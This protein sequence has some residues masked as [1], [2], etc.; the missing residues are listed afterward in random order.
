MAGALTSVLAV[1]VAGLP[2][3]AAPDERP[4]AATS[5]APRTALTDDA[6]LQRSDESGKR[7]EVLGRRTER[8]QTFANPDGT[9]TV[10]QYAQP[11]RTRKGGTWTDIDTTLVKQRNGTLAPRAT[12][13]AVTLSGGGDGPFATLVRDGRT[14]SLSWPG[15]LPA[16]E[17]EGA[18]A[19]YRAVLPDVDL[20]VR[21]EP[22]GFA[23]L[24]VVKSAEAAANPKLTAIDMPVETRG[25]DLSEAAGGGLV[26]KDPGT[27]GTVF[28][29]PQPVMWDSSGES[30]PAGRQKRAAAAPQAAPGDGARVADVSLGLRRDV[31]TLK[32]DMSLLRGENTRYPVIIDPV[33]RTKSRTAWTWVSSAKPGLEG[34]KF[35][36]SE[37]GVES[38]K[39][40]GRC[41]ANF[42]VRCTGSDDVQRQYY[43]L[44]TGSFE[45]KRILKAE[46][47]ITLVHTYNSEARSVQLH[48]VNSSGGSAINSRTNWSN[49]PS[50]K[51][52]ITSE[53]P[54]N[55]TGS[56]SATNQNVR[57]NVKGTV[58]KA[59][60][61]GWDTTTFGLQAAT[62][63]SYASWKRFCNNAALEVTYNRPPYQPRM[64]DLSM[65][66]GGKCAYGEATK[67]Y[68]K[69]VPTLS[70]EIWDPDHGDAHG[71]TETLRAQFEI[72][73][74][75]KN[76]DEKKYVVTTG[77]K[78]S[79]SQR[80][81]DS[82]VAG[83]SYKV[84]ADIR[85]D[86]TGKFTLPEN[87][88]IGWWVRGG[89][90]IAGSDE[91]WGPWSHEG[92]G[93][94]CE[95]ILDKTK[96]AAP[97][98]KSEKYPNDEKWHAGVGDYGTFELHSEGT[99]VV[100][101]SYQFTGE[102]ERTVT[103]GAPG[104]PVTLRWMPQRE[105]PMTLFVRAEDRAGNAKDITRSYRFRV[106]KG[107]SAKASWALADPV[108]SKQA[109]GNDNTPAATAGSGVTF[110]EDGPHGSVRTAATLNG[111]SGAYLN[112]G[113]HVVDTDKTFSVAAW[114]Q[115]P[116]LPK[117]SMSVLSQDGTA[118]S[119]FSLGYD[120]AS[121]RW[122]FLAPD[123]EM[124]S[125]IS[126]QVQGPKPVA[127]EWTH[128]VGVYDKDEVKA[129]THGTMR[130][131]VNGTLV[132]GDVQERPTSWNATGSL[133]IGRALEP[134]GY[135][136][137]LKGTVADAQVFDRVL[138]VGET[139][140]LG[141]LP[142]LQR[143]YWD[144]DESTDGVV[145]DRSEGRGLTMRGGAS[146]YQAEDSCDVLDP[147]CK[148][149]EQPLWGD[150]HLA[151]N[152]KDGYAARPAGLLKSKASFT[153]T[154][155][156]RL[157]SPD[158]TASQTVFSLPGTEG[159]AATVRF[160]KESGRWQL[161][162]TEKDTPDAP[163]QEATAKG[164]EPSISGDGDH[165]ALSYNALFEEVRLYVNGQW[166]DQV[167]KWP[168]DWDFATT[169]VQVGRSGLT[170]GSGYFSGAID[171]VRVFEGAFDEALVATVAN[172]ESGVNLDG[173]VT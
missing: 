123:S 129:G 28:E 85:G 161:R 117:T 153:V 86:G 66:Y 62:E 133:Q 63:D 138:A 143:A 13:T 160:D 108:G 65:D 102:D 127:G 147:N 158:A 59:A 168:N 56:C 49:R 15:K 27:G 45:D 104:R 10:K 51:D 131:Y 2:A 150:G 50:S 126:W 22:E 58:Q 69:E 64:D 154:A 4:S 165:L 44:P 115:L 170:S 91:S 75:D 89:D 119:G 84:G 83:F 167:V 80:G 73:W 48:R 101:Y 105:A 169:G 38:G 77:Y 163:V 35:P 88:V 19:T 12:P 107:R 37:D 125:M 26:A 25:V 134:D 46:F 5:P 79:D 78:Q 74:T 82:G 132:K 87:T 155:R 57:F 98:V 156:A 67:H 81:R 159:A 18:T 100:K 148:V 23:H 113:Q 111:G 68:T 55:P 103:P 52:H 135:T 36:N 124:N 144:M 128:L 33:A 94:R 61:S 70:A 162:L 24:L 122:S 3:A 152:G 90:D 76:G 116:E 93:T 53:S 43:A 1:V 14:L 92:S 120:A 21:A 16:P 7:V 29:A 110:G 171:E 136:A 157:A 6:A 173:T 130:M 96:P 141:G 47:A 97:E 95:F 145:P 60:S 109:A 42:S 140:S 17:V 9:L 112:T 72:F 41:P 34:W 114:V 54:T 8:S 139:R 106:A 32:P 137:N 164:V 20:V 118:Q 172:L 30:R 166:T 71:N 142:P 40:V 99:D 149:A 146:V 39:G 11:V 31:M 151:L 121:R